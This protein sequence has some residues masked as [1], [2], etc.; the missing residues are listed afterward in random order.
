MSNGCYVS[1]QDLSSTQFPNIYT[2]SQCQPVFVAVVFVCFFLNLCLLLKKGRGCERI[3]ICGLC[4]RGSLLNKY[5]KIIA[6][7]SF[8]GSSSFG[9]AYIY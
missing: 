5:S 1:N 6:L 7:K 9:G 8:K 3:I 2:T 4:L